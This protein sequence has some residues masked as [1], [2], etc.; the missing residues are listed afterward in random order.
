[1]KQYKVTSLKKFKEAKSAGKL[2]ELPVVMEK[3][4]SADSSMEEVKSEEW[5]WFVMNNS[6]K[7]SSILVVQT[8]I[9]QLWF[10]VSHFETDRE[11]KNS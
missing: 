9:I 5:I 10:S 6:G 4:N 2:A 7:V 1:M 3:N 11:I 8:I